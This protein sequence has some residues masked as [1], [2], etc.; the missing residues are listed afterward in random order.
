MQIQPKS[1][2]GRGVKNS[3]FFNGPFPSQIAE[4]FLK[5]GVTLVNC[6]AKRHKKN[7]LVTLY[8]ACC[9]WCRKNLPKKQLT[10][11]HLIPKS[12]GGSNSLENLRLSCVECNRARGNSLYPP[13]HSLGI[14]QG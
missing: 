4:H 12:R 9:W 13:A 11:D 7:K 10:L 1:S 6:H 5:T 14:K 3:L 2:N 8:G